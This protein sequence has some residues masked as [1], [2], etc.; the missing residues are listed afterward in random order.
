MLAF[1]NSHEHGIS[2]FV[3]SHKDGSFAPVPIVIAAPCMLQATHS[4]F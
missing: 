1:E 3:I 4:L 2:F